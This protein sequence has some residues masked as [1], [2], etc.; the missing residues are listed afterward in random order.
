[1]AMTWHGIVQYVVY[2][3]LDDSPFMIHFLVT[4]HIMRAKHQY[5][6]F[7]SITKV[8]MSMHP[9]TLPMPT[10]PL[11][12]AQI[13]LQPFSVASCPVTRDCYAATYCKI[14]QIPTLK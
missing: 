7:W 9:S 8:S 14:G 2:N 4:L 10:K 6:I 3:N 12:H 11:L 1:M 5:N 13:V